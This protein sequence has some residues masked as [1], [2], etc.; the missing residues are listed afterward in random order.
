MKV[1]FLFL[2]WIVW[3]YDILFVFVGEIVV[4][5]VLYDIEEMGLWFDMVLVLWWGFDEDFVM[6]LD[7][8]EVSMLFVYVLNFLWFFFVRIIYDLLEGLIGE[9][10]DIVMWVVIVVVESGEEWIMF[11]IVMV[12]GYV[13]LLG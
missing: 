13:L 5:D 12:F 7:S 3:V 6:F 8:F 4:Y 9:V 10:V 2:W 1:I 11:S